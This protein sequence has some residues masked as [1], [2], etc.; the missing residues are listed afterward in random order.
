M[1]GRLGTEDV[2]TEKLIEVIFDSDTLSLISNLF[3]NIFKCKGFNISP[4]KRNTYDNRSF[5]KDSQFRTETDHIMLYT[6][7]F[8]MTSLVPDWTLYQY[9]ITFD[10]PVLSKRLKSELIYSCSKFFNNSV[11][12]DGTNAFSLYYLKDVRLLFF[13]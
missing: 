1:L 13:K 12:Y 3:N 2:E 5:D 9:E 8:E 6:N 4:S 7:Y 11:A 10:P